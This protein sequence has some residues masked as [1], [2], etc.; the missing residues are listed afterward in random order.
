MFIYFC[1]NLWKNV[2]LLV[3]YS[4]VPIFTSCLKTVAYKISEI[5]LYNKIQCSSIVNGDEVWMTCVKFVG[6][7]PNLSIIYYDLSALKKKTIILFC[8]VNDIITS[9]LLFNYGKWTKKKNGKK[10][11]RWQIWKGGVRTVRLHWPSSEV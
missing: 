7:I 1:K 2:V 11:R 10:N 5:R 8:I 9:M 6:Y 4:R 3:V